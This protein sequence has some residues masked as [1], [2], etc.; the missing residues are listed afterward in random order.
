MLNCPHCKKPIIDEQGKGWIVNRFN[1]VDGAATL[2]FHC[3]EPLP[4]DMVLRIPPD[5]EA[6]YTGL[7]YNNDN[8]DKVV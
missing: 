4:T 7:D 2:C 6:G 3:K 5:I 8:A 1:A